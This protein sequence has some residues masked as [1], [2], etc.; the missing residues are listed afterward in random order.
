M[1]WTKPEYQE[2]SLNM[3]VTAYVNTDDTI[4][5]P[6]ELRRQDEP[7]SSVATTGGQKQ[8]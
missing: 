7:S 3:E 6:A 2:I 4:V 5:K 1:Q 8:E